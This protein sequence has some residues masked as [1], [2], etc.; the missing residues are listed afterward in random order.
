MNEE[1]RNIS[2]EDLES[3]KKFNL[4]DALME[5]VGR[6]QKEKFPR[7]QSKAGQSSG[8]SLLL[9]PAIDEYFCASHDAYGY[10]VKDP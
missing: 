4:D 3:W 7:R 5:K 9:Y 6:G 8:L 2:P 10:R 1:Q